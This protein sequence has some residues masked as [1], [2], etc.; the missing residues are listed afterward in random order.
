[1]NKKPKYDVINRD[2][3]PDP[4]ELMERAIEEWHSDLVPCRIVLL[5]V[6]RTKEDKDGRLVLGRCHPVTEADREL[7]QYDRKIDLNREA[8]EVLSLE[9]RLALV[10]H[11]LCHIGPDLDGDGEQKMDGHGKLK[12]RMV[13]HYIEEHLEIV[14]RHGLYKADLAR[15]AETALRKNPNLDLFKREPEEPL[16]ERRPTPPIT[17]VTFGVPGGESVT[18][19]SD[20][21]REIRRNLRSVR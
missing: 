20:D 14:E 9:Q 11:E 8:W 16:A 19:T 18:I 2:V 7:H 21:A 1:M 15:F 10:D 4:W 6:Y 12:W 17:S 5:W 3:D 13:K